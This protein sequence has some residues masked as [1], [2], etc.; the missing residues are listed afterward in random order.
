MFKCA[1]QAS[2]NLTII[3]KS[4]R[5]SAAAAHIQLYIKNALKLDRPHD[6]GITTLLFTIDVCSSFKSPD[7][8][9]TDWTYGLTSL[10]EKA[11][12]SNHLQI[13]EQRQHLFLNYFK[14][15]SGGPAGN[16]TQASRTVNWR[17]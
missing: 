16:R 15:L 7:R 10:S 14:T 3:I 11:R 4:L 2:T 12:R 13:L 8:G 6:I 5:W 17:G 9:S 1:L